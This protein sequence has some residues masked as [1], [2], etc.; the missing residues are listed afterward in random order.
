MLNPSLRPLTAD[1]ACDEFAGAAGPDA[2]QQ[3]A[4]VPMLL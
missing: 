4:A 2:P 3:D 1:N